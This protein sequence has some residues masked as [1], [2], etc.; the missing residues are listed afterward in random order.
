MPRRTCRLPLAT[1]ALLLAC[2]DDGAPIGGTATTGGDSTGPGTTEPGTTGPTTG[3]ATTSIMTTDVTTSGTTGDPGSTGDSASTGGTTGD[4]DGVIV[5][6]GLSHPE[7]ILWDKQADVFLI[8][9]I[10][11]APDVAD[12]NGFIAR[13]LP[14]GTI[15]QLEWISGAGD[16]ELHAPKGMAIVGD[17]LYVTDLTV[18]HKFH[19]TTG[20][21][22]GII[23]VDGAVFLNDLSADPGGAV[24]VSDSVANSVHV[25]DPQDNVTLLLSDPGLGG[26][27]GLFA[28]DD[29]V[30]AV[31]YDDVRLFFLDRVNPTVFTVYML[32]TGGLDG[33]ARTPAGDWLITSW[34]GNGVYRVTPDLSAH[35]L[36]LTDIPSP[37]DL[38]YD[39]K[40]DRAL[41]PLL[42]E[43][44]A[45]LHPLQ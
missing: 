6:P 8:S 9:N 31:S 26:P 29:G 40:R 36:A 2:G 41:I 3:A 17:T 18:V 19:R 21:D 44:R 32:D 33:I 22:L 7:S 14:D 34:D 39:N 37:A 24:Y 15:E 45:E 25:I 27:N 38:D 43:D 35:E 1:L 30:Y 20:A 28:T 23:K 13:V 10:N 11:G 5:I 12:D 42:L 16:I 4:P